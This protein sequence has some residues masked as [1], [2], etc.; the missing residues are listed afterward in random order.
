MYLIVKFTYNLIS[1]PYIFSKYHYLLCITIALYLRHT[2]NMSR[3]K[4]GCTYVYLL[5]RIKLL[6][7]KNITP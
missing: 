5:K 3:I 7:N 6:D 2:N 1:S 4:F